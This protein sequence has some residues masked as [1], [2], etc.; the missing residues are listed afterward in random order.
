M[1]LERI[2]MRAVRGYTERINLTGTRL[3]AGGIDLPLNPREAPGQI[4]YG[5]LLGGLRSRHFTIEA[6]AS[7][8][9]FADTREF[10]SEGGEARFHVVEAALNVRQTATEF[11]PKAARC[12][13]P[14]G[15]R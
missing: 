14:R 5:A 13:V 2:R 9:R 10:N 8:E 6:F 3:T 12:S 11:V 15:L 1:H 4:V 7:R